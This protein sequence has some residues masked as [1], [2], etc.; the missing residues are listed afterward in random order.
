LANG[1]LGGII[2]LADCMISFP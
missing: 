1:M 2:T